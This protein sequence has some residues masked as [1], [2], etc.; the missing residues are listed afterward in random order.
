MSA[1]LRHEPANSASPFED[2]YDHAVGGTH[3]RSR[4][5]SPGYVS[6]P[7]GTTI[8]GRGVQNRCNERII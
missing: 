5:S 7:T 6:N 2:D 4:T 3:S 8:L 1:L